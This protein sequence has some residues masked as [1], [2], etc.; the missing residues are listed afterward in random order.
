MNTQTD[1]PG[2]WTS[3]FD[4]RYRRSDLDRQP[5]HVT[6]AQVDLARTALRLEAGARVLDLGCG[7]GRH[8]I[9]LAVHGLDVTGVDLNEDYLRH[10]RERA[11]ARG[12]AARFI[13]ADMRDL[14]N[15]D[16]QYFDGVISLYTSFGFFLEPDDNLR[17]LTEVRR[18]LRP[19]GRLLLDVIN[20]DWLLRT[21]THSDFV[22]DDRGFV[23]RDYDDAGDDVVLHE[24]AFDATTSTLTWTIR[25]LTEPIGTVVAPY[26][27]Y[28]LHE[29]LALIEDAGLL[30]QRT[31]GA[32]D[33]SP[34]SV[35]S[36]RII[37]IAD[38]P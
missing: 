1:R 29:L 12:V 9:E 14:D 31:F 19:E 32:Y 6:E 18:V 37:A 38:A 25:R 16:S 17:V 7:T 4:E 10:A 13:R 2:W 21:F 15:L 8:S 23:I 11:T 22:T 27:V 5:A 20:R 30:R 26:R 28:S 34:F 3:F 35:H 36:P 24:D 33:G